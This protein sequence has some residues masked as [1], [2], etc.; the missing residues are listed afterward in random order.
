[1]KQRSYK[2]KHMFKW[3]W[4]V[5]VPGWQDLYPTS[6]GIVPVMALMWMWRHM[7]IPTFIYIFQ[8]VCYVCQ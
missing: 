8:D 6:Y 5:I 3:F 4:Y 7:L 1:M 2:L